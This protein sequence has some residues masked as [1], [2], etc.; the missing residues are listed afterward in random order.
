MFS[1]FEKEKQPF[2]HLLKYNMKQNTYYNK[3][4][5]VN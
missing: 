4:Q 5:W 2:Y 1:I 3:I